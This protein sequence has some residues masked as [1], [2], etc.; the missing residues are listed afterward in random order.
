MDFRLPKYYRII[1]IFAI[2]LSASEERM[3][4]AST[5][6]IISDTPDYAWHFGCFGTASGN[7]IGYWDRHEFPQLYT[8]VV[9]SGVAPLDSGGANADIYTMWT[10]H[11]GHGGRSSTN[12]GHVDDYFG[13][14]PADYQT[15]NDPYKING[16]TVHSNDCIADF[17]G[18]SHYNWTN[19]NGECDGNINAF[20]VNYWDTSGARRVNFRPPSQDGKAVPDIQ[21]GLRDFTQYRGYRADTFSQLAEVHSLTPAGTGFTFDNMI[22]EIDAGFPVLLFLQ[23]TDM[24]RDG[25]T[26]NP[27][28]HG[29]MAYGYSYDLTNV[30]FAPDIS[31]YGNQGA[32]LGPA[33]T[34]DT[35]IFDTLGE[36]IDVADADELRFTNNFSISV[37]C[38]MTDSSPLRTLVDKMGGVNA[39]YRL[40]RSNSKFYL[41]GGDGVT[42]NSLSVA[43]GVY[44]DTNASYHVVG[45]FDGTGRVYVNGAP[46]GTD[47]SDPIIV[48]S[49]DLGI[50][51]KES[52]STTYYWLGGM[53]E[54]AIYRRALTQ[55][56]VSSIYT[57][58]VDREDSDL[59]LFLPITNQ[60]QG[61]LRQNETV[62]YR[63]SWASGDNTTHPWISGSWEAGLALRGVIGFYPKLS[64]AQTS[65]VSG[66]LSTSTWWLVRSSTAETIIAEADVFHGGT[67]YLFCGWSMDGRRVPDDT[68]EAVNPVA[69]ITIT[70]M[71]SAVAMY[72]PESADTDGDGLPDWWEYYFFGSTNA[73]PEEDA[74][75]DGSQNAD[76]LI[77]GTN[78][79]NA[80]DVL[81]G[82]GHA[83]FTSVFVPVLMWPF[84]T[85]REYTIYWGD[86][87]G[88]G[89]DLVWHSIT[90]PSYTVS[91]GWS[92]W[93]DTNALPASPATGRYYRIS[94]TGP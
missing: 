89:D 69:G 21:A 86:R 33:F 34:N 84:A 45:T 35:Y 24:S 55:E 68:S 28:I 17:L 47:T 62:R 25:G 42:W 65:S 13:A 66:V 71:M 91:N 82:R 94:V 60:T 15:T 9:N 49:I 52:L 90:N 67:N 23:N 29:M 53:S 4:A 20:C 37:R 80:G 11:A 40:I 26:R 8:G 70:S 77:A 6:V 39:G 5:N 61:V 87:S 93:S 22:D 19:L 44:T 64:I 30:F 1:F 78:P 46:G 73:L 16:W 2:L 83:Q 92:R 85:N 31:G 18:M 14:Y 32:V 79:R 27:S 54:V 12:R 81:A 76:E 74:D 72:L 51:G 38:T 59:V 50:G 3:H 63:T 75:G 57:N 48:N 58:G 56:E 41:Q 10:S 7:L 88:Y 36:R 43:S